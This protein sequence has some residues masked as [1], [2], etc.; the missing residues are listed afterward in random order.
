MSDEGKAAPP[1]AK[2]VLRYRT[3]RSARSTIAAL[4]IRRGSLYDGTRRHRG[5]T[6]PGN[7]S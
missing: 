2:A 3:P 7:R 1:Q 5:S 6:Q 4:G